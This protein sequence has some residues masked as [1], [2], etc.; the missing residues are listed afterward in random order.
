MVS[1]PKALFIIGISGASGCGKTHLSNIIKNDLSNSELDNIEIIS[2]DNYYKPYPNGQKAPDD[3]NWDRP[4]S[5]DLDLLENHIMMLK[6]GETIN[7]P[8]YDFITHQRNPDV[9]LLRTID[10]KRTKVVIVEGLFVLQK[11]GLRNLFDLKIFTWLDPDICLARRLIRDYKE[12]QISY[13]Q[14]LKLYQTNVKPA[15]VNFIEP[16]KKF[17][18]IIISTSEYN[19]GN[20]SLDIIKMYVK[21]KTQS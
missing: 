5:L 17:A 21:M 10:G 3:Y 2:C 11:E 6:N 1:Q 4:D 19:N 9:S 20:V 8:T 18:D 16:T 12:R 15:Y 7:I 13:E 14:T